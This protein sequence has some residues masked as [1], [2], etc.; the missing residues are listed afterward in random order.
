MVDAGAGLP[1]KG[2]VGTTRSFTALQAIKG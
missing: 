2:G 1:C